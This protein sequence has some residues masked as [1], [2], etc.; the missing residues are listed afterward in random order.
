MMD[1]H[2][3][4][5][6]AGTARRDA[7]IELD[8]QPVTF[9]IVTIALNRKEDLERTAKSVAAQRD[10]VFEWIVI[11][12]GSTDGTLDVIDA[13]SESIA[14]W[15]SEKD[16]GLYDAMN[17][18]LARASADYVLFLNAGDCFADDNSLQVVAQSI[19]QLGLMPDMVL[20]GAAYEFPF[21]HRMIQKPRKIEDHIHHS[22]PA[23][24]QAVF[25][26]R[27]V[28]QHYPYDTS[29]RIAGDYDCMCRSYLRDESCSYIDDAVV[30]SS[31]DERSVTHRHPWVHAK[32]CVRI[33]RKVLRIGYGSIVRS[34]LRRQMV[35]VVTELM[36]RRGVAPVTWRIIRAV[37]PT[38]N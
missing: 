36:S 11:D 9:S 17:K 34:L 1:I 31:R 21:G 28:H 12:G 3:G 6:I 30:V 18:G 22:T 13:H 4:E 15:Q 2:P 37:R 27:R 16:D 25:F 14:Y 7:A 35:Y 26:S 10:A 24:H 20:A 8:T 29:Y 32:E 5:R 23:T 38:V 33:Q 19:A